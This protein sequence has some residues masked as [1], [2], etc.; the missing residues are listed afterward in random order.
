MANSR[1]KL[2]V[3]DLDGTA[4]D[5]KKRIT[6]RAHA[7]VDAMRL[8]DIAFTACSGRPAR[9]MKA[10]IDDLGIEDV[11]FGAL[12]GGVYLN[13]DM[14]VIKT[15]PIGPRL[16]RKALSFYQERGISV[17]LFTATD[18]Y[19]LDRKGVY[20][21]HEVGAIKYEPVV[22]SFAPY[23][24]DAV[25][26]VG[27]S[28]DFDKL[29]ELEPVLQAHIGAGVSVARSNL[30]FLDVTNKRANKGEFVRWLGKRLGVRK[31][32]T[33]SLGDMTCDA[34]MFERSR[35]GVAMAN[36]PQVVQDAATHITSRNDD[37][38]FATAIESLV[39]S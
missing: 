36:A 38:G 30:Y 39:L 9:A 6:A 11:P 35:I 4:L 7:A 15:I 32:Q 28:D 3:T 29:A 27:V 19:V 12:N 22:D 18:W 1:I 14:S 8:Q 2:V 13:P 34:R 20:V 24:K 5:P 31:A 16:A 17:W 26:I 37:E 23:L 33:A 25:K 21:D 10:I